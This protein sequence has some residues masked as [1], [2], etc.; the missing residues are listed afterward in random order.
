MQH[1]SSIYEESDDKG[2]DT[3]VSRYGGTTKE[4]C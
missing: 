2:A 4:T 3:T 1:C